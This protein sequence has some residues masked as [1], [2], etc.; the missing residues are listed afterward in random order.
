M[1]RTRGKRAR[2]KTKIMMEEESG[3][4]MSKVGTGGG[5]MSERGGGWDPGGFLCPALP[6][7]HWI[8]VTLCSIAEC[9]L[10]KTQCSQADK[11]YLCE[12]FMH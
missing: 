7:P 6:C 3:R 10:T 12:N 5:G 4:G 9:P 1:A 2:V 11:N 8:G